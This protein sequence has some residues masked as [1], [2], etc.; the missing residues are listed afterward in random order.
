MSKP[1]N[2]YIGKTPEG[3]VICDTDISVLQLAGA[4]NITALPF[5]EYL[6]AGNHETVIEFVDDKPEVGLSDRARK[7]KRK[8]E[9]LARFEELDKLRARPVAFLAA[10]PAVNPLSDEIKNSEDMK[11]LKELNEE[12]EELREE[13]AALET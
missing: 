4:E 9:I 10:I 3:E 2:V 13:L 7:A 5:E 12:A 1:D 8:R 11:R 6:Q